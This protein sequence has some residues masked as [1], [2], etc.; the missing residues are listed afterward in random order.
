[1]KKFLLLFSLL[2]LLVGCNNTVEAEKVYTG[3]D[4]TIGI[5]GTAPKIKETN[6]TFEKIDF[7]DLTTNLEKITS[8]LDAIIITKEFLNEA[9]EDKYVSV[10]INSTI[11]TFF[12]E[13]TKAHVP[14]TNEGV[15]YEDFPE[16]DASIYAIGFLSTESDEGFNEQTWRYQ[17]KDNKENEQNIQLVYTR[18]FETIESFN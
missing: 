11:P 6:V 4:L 2:T 13:S 18:M 9:D 15:D 8:D 10:Y 17:L 16:V 7:N 5:I 3:K 1:M 12:M 14:F